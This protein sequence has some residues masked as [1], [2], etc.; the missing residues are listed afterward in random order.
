MQ[1]TTN[2]IPSL[3]MFARYFAKY[4]FNPSTTNYDEQMTHTV[5]LLW[6]EVMRFMVGTVVDNGLQ[7]RK[8]PVGT[9]YLWSNGYCPYCGK[10]A[11]AGQGNF[12]DW[13]LLYGCHD[14]RY[15]QAMVTIFH[16]RGGKIIAYSNLVSHPYL[17]L[18]LES[19]ELL[20]NYLGN[21]LDTGANPC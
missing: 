11:H 10:A 16:E 20:D 12:S 7:Q 13:L 17:L 4:P 15:G 6:P 9:K 21:L 19:C 2:Q 18:D 14:C 8:L 5:N 1:L 3:L